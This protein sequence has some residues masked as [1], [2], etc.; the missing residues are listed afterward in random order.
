MNGSVIRAALPALCCC[1]FYL[2]KCCSRSNPEALPSTCSAVVL[3]VLEWS[4][5][6]LWLGQGNLCLHGM[7]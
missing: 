5:T 4:I 3:G 6:A 2:Y 7:R 1:C